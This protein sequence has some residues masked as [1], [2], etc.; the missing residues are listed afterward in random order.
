MSPATVVLSRPATAVLSRPAAVVLSRPA[1][2]VLSR[3]AAVV[4]SRPAAAVLSRLV[5]LG[6]ADARPGSWVAAN[7]FNGLSRPVHLL[8][9]GLLM[10]A[11]AAGLWLMISTASGQLG[12]G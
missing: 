3:P 2:V 5:H 12:Y 8:A 10:Q 11:R 4:L 6:A 9:A 1:A 7:D